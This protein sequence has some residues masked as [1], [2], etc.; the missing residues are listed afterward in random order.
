MGLLS[1]IFIFLAFILSFATWILSI[2]FGAISLSYAKKSF[3]A[4]G[5]ECTEMKNGRTMGKIGLIVGSV[6]MGVVV[7]IFLIAF[8]IVLATI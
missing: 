3:N 4:L 7:L 6:L 5:Y 8:I 2:I 1:V